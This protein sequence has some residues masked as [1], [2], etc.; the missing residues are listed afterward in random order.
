MK[1]G[2]TLLAKGNNQFGLQQ[3]ASS[4]EF[5]IYTSKKTVVR[6][7]LPNDWTQNWHHVA[8]VYDGK[9][10]SLFIDNKK[11]AEEPVTGKITNFPF[12]L[13]VGKNAE[14]HGQH[15]SRYLC[16]AIIDQVS[17]FPK[18]IEIN[19]L[20]TAK[21]DLKNR[22]ALWLDFE[23]EQK[24]GEFSA[25]E[26]AHVLMEVFFPIAFRSLKCGK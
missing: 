23:Q 1:T 2:G 22:A 15:M 17:I 10:I 20:F 19:D 5:Y 21:P 26:L 13:N 14:T 8:G 18:A 7:E 9:S 11:V 4:L 6:A 12:P 16:D 3:S 24:E 25:T